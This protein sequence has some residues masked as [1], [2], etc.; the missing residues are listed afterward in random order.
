MVSIALAHFRIGIVQYPS[1]F[2]F[3]R[4]VFPPSCFLSLRL[5]NIF[6]MKESCLTTAHTYHVWIQIWIWISHRRL[7]AMTIF[8]M[9]L[10]KLKHIPKV[11]KLF[12]IVSLFSE[13]L[14][15]THDL[16]WKFLDTTSRHLASPF[17]KLKQYLGTWR[18]SQ[19]DIAVM[20]ITE[21]SI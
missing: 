14:Q 20:T 8:T 19:A 7:H 18:I 16:N 6:F 21:N 3:Y 13:H 11:V 10:L 5:S 4:F 17:R 9:F 1:S 2:P 12:R 15:E